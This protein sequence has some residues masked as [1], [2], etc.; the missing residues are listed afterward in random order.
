MS[1]ADEKKRNFFN[2]ISGAVDYNPFI[3]VGL[4]GVGLLART[5]IM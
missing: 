1:D 3:C 4:D 2:V 5:G